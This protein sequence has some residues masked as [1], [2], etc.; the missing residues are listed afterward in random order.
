MAVWLETPPIFIQD[1]S[2]KVGSIIAS[3]LQLRQ[4]AASE[5]KV[6]PA[7]FAHGIYSLANPLN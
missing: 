1:V 4:S 2:F 5:L 3:A 6:R 7:S